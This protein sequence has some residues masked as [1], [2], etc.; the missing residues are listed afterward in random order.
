M[1][2]QKVVTAM[3]GIVAILGSFG[4]YATAQT[5]YVSD[6]DFSAWAVFH[7]NGADPYSGITPPNTSTGSGQAVAT[8]GDPGAYLQFSQTV[9]F[10]DSSFVGGIKTDYT[11]NPASQGPLSDLSLSADVEFEYP[12]PSGQTAY[13]L[14]LEQNGL[15]YYSFPYGLFSVPTGWTTVTLSN[16]SASEFDTD[17]M[18]GSDG[19]L[20]DGNQPDFSSKGAPIQ[21]GFAFGNII[22]G[23]GSFT[24]TYGV[25]NFLVESVPE[26]RSTALILLT[27]SLFL[28]LRLRTRGSSKGQL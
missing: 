3:A 25:D 17:P 13:Q 1:K 24:A 23:P 2:L 22:T 7:V 15:L 8:G 14:V 12:G 19:I 16:L 6:G 21:F 11:Y 28:I 10:G 4:S 27:A 9:D 5:V 26:P 20:P 18:A